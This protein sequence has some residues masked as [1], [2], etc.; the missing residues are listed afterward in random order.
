[1][2]FMHWMLKIYN[3]NSSNEEGKNLRE[4]IFATMPEYFIEDVIDYLTF[5]GRAEPNVFTP[6][7]LEVMVTFCSTF[8]S[9]SKLIRSA[10]IRAKFLELLTEI[11]F[12]G[13]QKPPAPPANY[14]FGYKQP[15]NT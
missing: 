4:A 12:L 7:M 11:N 10:I 6:Q 8:L 9:D 5:I 13:N 1:M 2:Q 14:G 15:A 3:E